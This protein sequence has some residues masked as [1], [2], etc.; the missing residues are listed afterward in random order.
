[1]VRIG[2]VVTE[3]SVKKKKEGKGFKVRHLRL[4][5]NPIGGHYLEYYKGT[6][7]PPNFKGELDM[8]SAK[9]EKV[10]GGFKITP[11]FG[12]EGHE[13]VEFCFMVEDPGA[14]GNWVRECETASSSVPD[15]ESVLG[16]NFLMPGVDDWSLDMSASERA[17]AHHLGYSART[18]NNNL[19]IM[20]H[21]WEKLGEDKQA[22]RLPSL[23]R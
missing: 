4:V 19:L 20:K 16:G 2:E 7:T 10:D 9:V 3:G 5:K 21:T 17:N 22:R 13:G 18:W 8:R 23:L 15:R 1:M 11:E 6:P 12:T 14:C